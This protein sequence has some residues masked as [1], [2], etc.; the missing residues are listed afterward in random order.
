MVVQI[1][2]SDNISMKIKPPPV[3][4]GTPNENVADVFIRVTQLMLILETQYVVDTVVII[5]SNSD[6]L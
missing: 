5:S 3:D 4:D 1:Y 2:A 6:N